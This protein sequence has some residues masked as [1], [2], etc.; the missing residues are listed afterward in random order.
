MTPALAASLARWLGVAEALPGA[1]AP[2][3]D[4]CSPA[5]LAWLCRTALADGGAWSED[6]PARWLGFAQGV[7]ATRHGI[8]ADSDACPPKGLAPAVRPAPPEASVA[9]ATAAL[10]RRYAAMAR[11]AGPGSGSPTS[12]GGVLALCLDGE[13]RAASLPHAALGLRL[14]Y[15]QGVLCALG[16]ADVRRERDVSRP[17]FHAAYRAEGAAVPPT[18]DRTADAA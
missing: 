6:K 2:D 7:M 3:P 17:L 13:A 4:P 10:F 18:R 5:N 8:P 9:G 12:P 16:I 14:G 11:A 1:R 15:V